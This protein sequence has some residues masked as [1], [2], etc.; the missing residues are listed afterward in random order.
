ML[1]QLSLLVWA[2]VLLCMIF[3]H[4]MIQFILKYTGSPA[5][6][7]DLDAVFCSYAVK[8]FVFDT[9]VTLYLSVVLVFLYDNLCSL[10]P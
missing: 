3:H 5:A 9:P 1:S 4:F 8:R 6:L 10:S 2:P 7:A